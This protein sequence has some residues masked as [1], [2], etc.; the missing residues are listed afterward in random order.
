MTRRQISE[1]TLPEIIMEF[2]RPPGAAVDGPVCAPGSPQYPNAAG[3]DPIQQK[4]QAARFR[5]FD[6]VVADRQVT[7]AG[8]A[9]MPT[10][11]LRKAVEEVTGKPVEVPNDQFA[12]FAREYAA[13]KQPAAPQAPAAPPSTAKGE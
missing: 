11:A 8:L 7:P 9:A 1:L 5:A 6:Q 4:A 3:T 13:A 12:A 10:D 2:T